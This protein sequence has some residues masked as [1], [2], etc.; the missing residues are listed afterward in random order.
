[1]FVRTIVKQIQQQLDRL[2]MHLLSTEKKKRELEETVSDRLSELCA[3]SNRHDL[4]ITDML[5]SWEEWQE[6]LEELNSGLIERYRKEA[7]ES[8]SREAAL[9]K[10]MVAYHDQLFALRR[11]ASL[12]A[13]DVWKHQMDLAEE[14][15]SAERLLSGLE[16]ID[17]VGVEVNYDLHE[18]LGV[19]E[20]DRRENASRVAD[21]YSCG[22]VFRGKVFRKAGIVAYRYPYAE[23]VRPERG[24]FSGTLPQNR[25]AAP[26]GGG[27]GIHASTRPAPAVS[28]RT[29]AAVPAREDTTREAVSPAVKSVPEAANSAVE[30][31]LEPSS[32]AVERIPEAVSASA[33]E[34]VPERAD[35]AGENESE[36]ADPA[37][38]DTT[39]EAA[40]LVEESAPEAASPTGEDKP[41]TSPD[42]EDAPNEIGE[43][44]S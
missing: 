24:A 40:A 42:G 37:E 22:Y 11:A 5:D 25:P 14:K 31:V 1:M 44:P 6:R 30:N 2:E 10:M 12:A 32:P 9:L 15:L 16:V 29:D 23:P 36:A 20:T 7:Q 21:V 38:G 41:E 26:S 34:D 28:V 13:E 33:G 3:A 18:V 27:S 17:R 35:P 8:W 43:E 19:V 39:G 4:G